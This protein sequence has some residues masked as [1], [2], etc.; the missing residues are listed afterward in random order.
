MNNRYVY[1]LV[2]ILWR[3]KNVHIQLFVNLPLGNVVLVNV[4]TVG[5]VG[6][7]SPS[8]SLSDAVASVLPP[9]IIGFTSFGLT[10]IVLKAPPA[11]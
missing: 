6:L 10:G 8:F 1:G 2:R 7:T 3:K 9:E 5:G 4:N 11:G